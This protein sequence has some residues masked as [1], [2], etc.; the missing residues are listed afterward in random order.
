MHDPEDSGHP[1]A[2]QEQDVVDLGLDGRGRIDRTQRPVRGRGIEKLLDGGGE[3]G[4]LVGEDAKDGA[5]G[6]A[7]GIRDLTGADLA[8]VLDEERDDGVDD[9]RPALVHRHGLRAGAGRLLNF[10]HP[11]TLNE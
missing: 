9:H 3:E 1:A 10:G 4:L 5:L 11:S 8:A 7:R 6:D 2:Q